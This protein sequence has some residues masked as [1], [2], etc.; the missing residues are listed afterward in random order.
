MV[1]LFASETAT[2]SVEIFSQP[3]L[4]FVERTITP[5]QLGQIK[6]QGVFWRAQL[7]DQSKDAVLQPAS[8]V[9]VLGR[10]GITLLV[11]TIT[12]PDVAAASDSFSDRLPIHALIPAWF[13]KLWNNKDG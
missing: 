4:G 1:I 13:A 6:F 8:P 11:E 3:G 9:M 2:S 5:T 7:Y 10:K 12:E